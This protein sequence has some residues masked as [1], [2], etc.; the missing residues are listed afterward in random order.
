MALN[1]RGRVVDGQKQPRRTDCQTDIQEVEKAEEM[2]LMRKG[3]NKKGGGGAKRN[4]AGV[5]SEV[6]VGVSVGVGS[7]RQLPSQGW[8]GWSEH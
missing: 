2:R 6:E 5:D 3:T 4:W 7:W 1:H 8:S